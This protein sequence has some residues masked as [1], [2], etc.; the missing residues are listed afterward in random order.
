MDLLGNS[1][2]WLLIIVGP[3]ICLIPDISIKVFSNWFARTPVDWQL[4]EIADYKQVSAVKEKD[5]M[6]KEKAKREEA[7]RRRAERRKLQPLEYG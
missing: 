2:V 7:L 1:K 4:K 6:I 5:K 3:F